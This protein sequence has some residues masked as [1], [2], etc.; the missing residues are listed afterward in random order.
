MNTIIFNTKQHTLTLELVSGTK[1]SYKDV[2]T[3]KLIDGIKIKT[4][5]LEALLLAQK[6]QQKRHQ[7]NQALFKKSIAVYRTDM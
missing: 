4:V 6:N 2:M 5:G 1:K 3:V 7:E